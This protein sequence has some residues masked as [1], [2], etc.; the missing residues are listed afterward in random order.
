MVGHLGHGDVQ[1]VRHEAQDG[2][3]YKASI[4][5]G[6]AVGYADDDAVSVR[7]EEVLGKLHSRITLH[8]RKLVSG[9]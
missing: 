1:V 6:G 3:D 9:C 4:H 7:R 2:E 8:D 5:T